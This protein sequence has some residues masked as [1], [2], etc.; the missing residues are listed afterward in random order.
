[1]PSQ[2]IESRIIKC[3]PV[4]WRELTW[5]QTSGLKDLTKQAYQ[6]LYHSLVNNQFIDPFRIWENK[7]KQYILDG[8]HRQVV[9]EAIE[10]D[11]IRIPDVLPGVFI[12]CKDIK[13]AKKLVLVYSAVYAQVTDEGLYE[14]ISTEELDFDALKLEL[15]L[16]RL[17]LDYFEKGWIDFTSTDREK[18]GVNSTWDQVK[19]TDNQRII[20]GE[21]ESSISISMSN[22]IVELLNYEY[23]FNNKP[24]NITLEKILLY[25][26]EK[27][28][29]KNSHP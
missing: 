24:I 10:K 19:N 8:H 2:S 15:D 14:Y 5:L 7:T 13:E 1:M 17:D 23:Q 26:I 9:M 28:E 11:G 25:G 3:E 29:T 21:I 16:P 4:K 27:Y 12:D 22:R 20:I 6:K 18:Q